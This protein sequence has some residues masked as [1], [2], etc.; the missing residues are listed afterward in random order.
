MLTAALITHSVICFSLSI[1]CWIVFSKLRAIKGALILAEVRSDEMRRQVPQMVANLKSMSFQAALQTFLLNPA[2]F[3]K[4]GELFLL[5]R[6][7]KLN[8]LNLIKL[9]VKA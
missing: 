7:G 2:T 8:P 1:V 3:V 9:I 6:V 5:A 4:L